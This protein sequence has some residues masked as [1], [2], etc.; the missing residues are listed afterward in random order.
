MAKTSTA[1]NVSLLHSV[2]FNS[3]FFLS[4]VNKHVELTFNTL[5]SKI[6]FCE[7]SQPYEFA[8]LLSPVIG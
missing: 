4:D 3:G 8:L 5:K 1:A 2:G 6:A 7:E